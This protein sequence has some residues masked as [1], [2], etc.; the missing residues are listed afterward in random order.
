MHKNHNLMLI[1]NDVQLRSVSA[2]ENKVNCMDGYVHKT[3]VSTANP[4]K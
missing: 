1:L 4:E 2:N 3:L